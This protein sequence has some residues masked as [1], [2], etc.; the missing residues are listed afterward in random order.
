MNR[1][2]H[3]ARLAVGEP[4]LV[5]HRT[6]WQHCAAGE[7]RFQRCAEC[8]TWRHPP[9]PRCPACHSV[10]VRWER[11][12]EAAELYSYTVVHHPATPALKDALPYNVAI[13]AFPAAGSLRL[14]SCVIDAHPGEL[15]IGMPLALAWARSADGQALPVF[16][17]V[18]TGRIGRAP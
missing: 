18:S 13:V 17:R 10:N 5:E 8:A 4:H 11:A 2:A 15:A 12:P 7:L 6:F 3:L 9:G 16:T 14:I 1:A